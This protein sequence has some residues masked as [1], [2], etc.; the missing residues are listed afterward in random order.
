MRAIVFDDYGPPDVLQLREVAVPSPMADEILIRIAAAAVNPADVKWR[1]GMFRDYAPIGFPHILGYDVAGTVESVGAGVTSFAP[2]D[3]VDAML[4][5]MSKGGYA[6]YVA[7]AAD[8][9]ARI[10]ANLEFST[11]AAIPCA[12]LTGVQIM[13]ESIQLKPGE[14]VLITGATG[15]VG[16]LGVFAAGRLGG[17]VVAAVRASH[18]AEARALGAAEVVILG[19]EDWTGAPFDHVF[20]TVGGPAVA[21]LCRHL[22]PGGRIRTAATT[23]IDPEGL[24]TMP[25]FVPVHQDGKRLREL[26]EDV[27]AGRIPV[28]IARRMPL[29]AAVDAHQ[30]LE[31]GGLGG[32]IILE[33]R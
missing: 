17:R 28:P 18:A 15:A 26:A 24:S 25:L 8:A 6:E 22:A 16:R 2:G 21:R 3:R 4:D 1:A 20:D 7:I 33:P 31:A 32:K 27:A 9:A 5:P 23:P 19:E 13:E 12:G 11:A 14:T 10:P 29:E 30:L